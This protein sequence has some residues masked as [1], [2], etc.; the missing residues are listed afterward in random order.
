[1]AIKHAEISSD[2][3]THSN[4]TGMKH[5]LLGLAKVLTLMDPRSYSNPWIKRLSGVKQIK[6]E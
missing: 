4:L 6:K 1:M 2:N 5:L 3:N